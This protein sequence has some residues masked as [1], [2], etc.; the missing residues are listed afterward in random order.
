M[1]EDGLLLIV[2]ILTVA[3]LCLGN[4]ALK[5]AGRLTS[6]GSQDLSDF[7]AGVGVGSGGGA[8]VYICHM[9]ATA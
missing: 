9:R 3:V 5:Q 7:P 4:K 8:W 1:K 2:C 6:G